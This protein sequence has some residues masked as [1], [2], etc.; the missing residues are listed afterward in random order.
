MADGIPKR[1]YDGDVGFILGSN[2]LS[3]GTML[4]EQSYAFAWNM[5]NRGGVLRARPGFNTRYALPDGNLQGFAIF[6]PRIGFPQH[7]SVVDGQV[8][9]SDYPY[10]TCRPVAGATMSADAKQ[11]YFCQAVKTAQRNADTSITL[12]DPQNLLFLQDGIN[13]PAYYDGNKVTAVK[14][15]ALNT[16]QGT[17]MAWDGFRLWV[18]RD[19]KLFASDLSDPLSFYE[20]QFNTLGGLSYFVLPGKITAMGMTGGIQIPQLLV[21]TESTCTTFQSNIPDRTAW[22]NTYLFQRLILPGIG[23]LSHRSLV[24]RGGLLSWYSQNGWTQA[25]TAMWNMQTAEISYLDSEMMR[26]KSEL[27]DDL[28]V[29]AASTKENFLLVSVPHQSNINTHTWVNDASP[30]PSKSGQVPKAWSSVWT[31]V[32]PVQWGTVGYGETGRLFCA[33][34]DSDGHNRVYE[35][36]QETGKDNGVD[37]PW[38]VEFRPY[39]GQIAQPKDIVWAELYLLD[40]L[41]Q[42]DLNISWAGADRGRWKSALTTTFRAA[43]GN[44]DAT[45][46]YDSTSTLFAYKPQS[47]QPRT[48]EIADLEQDP[49]SSCNI[50]FE[51]NERTDT[52][53]QI[54][55]DGSGHAAIAMVRVALNA[56]PDYVEREVEC[57]ETEDKFT[58]FDGAASED[59]E[60]LNEDLVSYTSTQTV[61][62]RIGNYAHTSSATVISYI[63]QS[64]AD[65]R[66]S[67]TADTLNQFWFLNNVPAYTP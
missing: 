38:A 17:V 41:G 1:V 4:P 37:F 44:I 30:E 18:A 36:F 27:A 21:F 16:P 60:D 45:Q 53:F 66:A 7:V 12:V 26:S 59:A 65:K 50:D 32:C 6:V 58:R 28:S 35:A 24:D 19:E 13:P 34:V 54:R 67:Q 23:C 31:G 20:Q 9:V 15:N 47:R 63:S 10:N 51:Q 55:V 57:P 40:I 61:T 29:I 49:L 5:T 64:D 46:V 22:A 11:V 8:Y 33:S 43:V 56:L 52:A 42:V 3:R 62:G 2:S 25:D 14:G 48:Q 39:T